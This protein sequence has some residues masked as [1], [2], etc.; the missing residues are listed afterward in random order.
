MTHTG[1]IIQNRS[2]KRQRHCY[3]WRET[4]RQRDNS[5]VSYIYSAHFLWRL[6]D[7]DSIGFNIFLSVALDP[8]KPPHL[9]K[10]GFSVPLIASSTSPTTI[11]LIISHSLCIP[12]TQ[13]LFFHLLTT[14]P[15]QLSSLWGKH[16]F[17][18]QRP[19]ASLLFLKLK[20][21]SCVSPT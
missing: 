20:T 2:R 7:V 8:V 1:L 13:S 14:T 5:V 6:Y 10:P 19:C 3:A 4:E 15:Y 12:S 9:I 21:Y 16:F 18:F 17:V 11:P